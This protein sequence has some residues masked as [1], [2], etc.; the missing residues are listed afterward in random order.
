MAV[1][2]NRRLPAEW[3]ST[4][5]PHELD[6]SPA[7]HRPEGQLEERLEN[8]LS[9][10]RTAKENLPAINNGLVST[11]RITEMSAL[12]DRLHCEADRRRATAVDTLRR[13]AA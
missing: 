6:T 1:L 4:P 10:I 11:D 8:I 7:Q 12:I 5:M 13:R 2:K 3:M 9:W